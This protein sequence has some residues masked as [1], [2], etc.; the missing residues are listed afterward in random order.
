LSGE[1]QDVL[2]IL[3]VTST[4]IGNCAAIAQT[5]IK[6]MLAYLSI[7]QMGFVLLGILAAEGKGYS[8]GNVLHCGFWADDAWRFRHDHGV[9]RT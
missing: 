3:A 5:N 6:R 8:A 1:G 9:E 7:L 2:I 4:A